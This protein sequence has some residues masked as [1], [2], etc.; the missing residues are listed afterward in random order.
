M[1][2][3]QTLIILFMLVIGYSASMSNRVRSSNNNYHVSMDD[4]KLFINDSRI[5]KAVE[6]FV[7]DASDRGLD[8]SL[9]ENYIKKLDHIYI[10]SELS[11]D[12]LGVIS[13][14][15][16]SYILINRDKVKSYVDLKLIIYHELGHWFGL[17]HSGGKLMESIR[18]SINFSEWDSYVSELMTNINRLII[19]NKTI[20]PYRE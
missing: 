2:I 11:D 17:D 15:D 16:T 9:V 8:K 12:E 1:N 7:K 10:S 6:E 18:P 20:K 4:D 3:K 19:E 14:G 5:K 13:I